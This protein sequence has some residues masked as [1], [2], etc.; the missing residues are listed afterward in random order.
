MPAD[1]PQRRRTIG[2]L[3]LALGVAAAYPTGWMLGDWVLFG[4]EGALDGF[5]RHWLIA[6]GLLLV[7]LSMGAGARVLRGW[8]PALL[9]ALIFATLGLG[10]WRGAADRIEAY[11][12]GPLNAAL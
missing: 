1:P 4:G 9:A 6:P 5:A 8:A 12:S 10:A 3:A 7:A 11:R 2:A